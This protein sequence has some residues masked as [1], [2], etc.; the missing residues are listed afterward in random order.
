MRDY[1]RSWIRRGR[2]ERR[3]RR[4]KNP[5]YLKYDIIRITALSLVLIAHVSAYIVLRFPDPSGEAFQVGTVFNR[6]F[7]H[8]WYLFMLLGIYPAIPILRLFV[9]AENRRYILGILLFSIIVLFIPCNARI[10][11]RNADFTIKDFMDKFYVHY[12]SAMLIY[13]LAGWYL[14]VFPPSGRER[15]L[16]I[17]AGAAAACVNILTVRNLIAEIPNIRGYMLTENSFTILLSA[18]GLFTFLASLGIVRLLARVRF[19]RKLLHY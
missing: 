4:G 19:M 7:P 1:I 2:I 13:I 9:K 6:N 18:A 16:L 14:T 3:V 8:L 11:T 17:A 10:L 15:V 12:I 5:R